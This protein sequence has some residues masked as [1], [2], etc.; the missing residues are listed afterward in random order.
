MKRNIHAEETA[1]L[2]A[3]A[4]KGVRP[5]LL[6]HSCCAPCSSHVVTYLKDY[7]D[8]TVFYYNPNIS[9][10]AEYEKR[11]AEQLRFLEQEGIPVLSC[12]YE[13]GRYDEAVRGL[14]EEP[15]RGARCTVCFALRLERT[16]REAAAGGFDYWCT[17]LTVSPHKDAALINE[18]GE[19]I[20]CAAGVP[21]LPSDFKKRDGY[22]R[23]VQLSAQYGLYRQN[24]C[25][26]RFSR[27]E[28]ERQKS[29]KP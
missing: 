25:G 28:R 7:F 12:G 2:A 15:E 11:R 26:C 20:G 16:A 13:G 19:R 21:F 17:T 6:L 27:A 18:L 22:R 4:E 10:E 14:E 29:R 1:L 5:R 24:Y 8:L 23:S 9:P 3:L